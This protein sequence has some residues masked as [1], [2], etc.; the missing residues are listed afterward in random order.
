MIILDLNKSSFIHKLNPITKIWIVALTSLLILISPG[1]KG[2]VI[3]YSI[4]LLVLVIL[5]IIGRIRLDEIS[6]I[7][8]PFIL[9]AILLI[10][11]QGFFYRSSE[12]FTPIFTIMNFYLEGRSIGTFSLEGLIAGIVGVMKILCVIISVQLFIMTTK[13]ED[14]AY[15]LT[16]L[17]VPYEIAFILITAMR[18]VPLVQETWSNLQDAQKLRGYD[19]DKIGMLQRLTEAYPRLIG[20]LV[21]V[22]FKSGLNLQ[23]SIETRGYGAPNKRTEYFILRMKTLD[24]LIIIFFFEIFIFEILLWVRGK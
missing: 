22:L 18:F 16:K 9:I 10:V 1:V 24:Y 6:K 23:V 19:I 21:I 4:W 20:A 8:K 11:M 3:L 13:L 7:A 14:F 12:S 17:G 2:G 15:S 5:W